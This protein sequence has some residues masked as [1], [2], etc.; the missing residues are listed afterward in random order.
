M[1]GEKKTEEKKTEEKQH[2]QNVITKKRF[3]EELQKVIVEETGNKLSKEASWELFKA[4]YKRMV[5]LACENPISLA[6]IGKFVVQKTRPRGRKQG[7]VEFVP[8]FKLRASSA[9]NAY[10]ENKM[11]VVVPTENP[12]D[13]SSKD[14]KP[15]PKPKENASKAASEV[16]DLD[17]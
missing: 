6:G 13:K 3:S 8:R 15:S 17:F 2:R 9:I 1:S 12:K 4:I 16:D 11:G 7:V 5:D 14:E 10:L